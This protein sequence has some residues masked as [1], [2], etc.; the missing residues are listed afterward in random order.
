MAKKYYGIDMQ[1]KLLIQR[2]SSLPAF[3]AGKDGRVFWEDTNERLY[4]Q[5][6]SDWVRV[7]LSDGKGYPSLS[8][9]ATEYAKYI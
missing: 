7:V 1:G 9:P 4:V 6:S 8:V 2:G 5:G 3:V